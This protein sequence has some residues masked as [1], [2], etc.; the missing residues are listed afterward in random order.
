MSGDLK[1]IV[2]YAEEFLEKSLESKIFLDLLDQAGLKIEH[3]SKN[4]CL[5]Y[6]DMPSKYI[7]ILLKGAC[8]SEKYSPS[9]KLLTAVACKPIE[10]YGLFEAVHPTLNRHTATI[11]CASVPIFVFLYK[12]I[13]I[14]FQEILNSECSALSICPY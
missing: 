5:I 4:D 6:N 11:R 10:I 3:A 12:H 13:W 14:N 9:G 8:Y 7:Y 2:E 1:K